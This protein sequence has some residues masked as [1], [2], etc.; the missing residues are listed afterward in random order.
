MVNHHPSRQATRPSINAIQSRASN[1]F[2]LD[3]HVPAIRHQHWLPPL[4]HDNTGQIAHLSRYT[5]S[6]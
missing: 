5:V 2:G 1:S 4:F 3:N 6:F